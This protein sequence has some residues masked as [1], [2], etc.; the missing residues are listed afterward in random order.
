MQS[1]LNNKLYG[2]LN[3]ETARADPL[4]G[5][6]SRRRQAMTVGL[7]GFAVLV[8]ILLLAVSSSPTLHAVALGLIAPGAGFLNWSM[9]GSPL[10][11]ILAAAW[12]AAFVMALVKW[13]A[14]GNVVAPALV[15]ITSP[16]AAAS[17]G[18]LE[19]ATA[20][21][22]TLWLVPA[23]AGLLIASWLAY[24]AF[25]GL[26][27]RSRA[28]KTAA[29]CATTP[30]PDAPSASEPN[31][32]TQE[33][34][35]LMRLVL[36]RALQPVDRFEGFEWV[37]QY[38]TSAVRYQINF[39][40]YAL[41]MAQRV[42]MPAFRGYLHAAQTNLADKQQDHRV[43]RYWRSENLW[44]NLSRSPDPIPRDNIM[45]SGFVATQLALFQNAAGQ[46]PFD[47]AESLVFAHPSG[48]RFAYDLPAIIE[49][50]ARGFEQSSLGLTAC[51]PHWLY[52]LCN[53]ITAS[54]IRAASPAH[55]E[56][57]AEQL[58]E[59][60]EG[61]FTAGEGR[62]VPFRSGLTGFAPPPLGGAVM[63]AF[64]AYFLSATLPDLAWRHWLALRPSLAQDRFRCAC[65]P[66]DVG[67][68]RFTRAS[69]Y[70]GT[71][72][73]AVEFGDDAITRR[74][75]EALDAECPAILR[76]GVR[77]R[78][79]VSLWSHAVELMA[80]CGTTHSFRDLVTRSTTA[81]RTGPHLD[82][83]PYPD[84]LVAKAVRERA[85][86]RLVLYPG[87]CTGPV[88]LKLAGLPRGR[89]FFLRGISQ[90]EGRAN[91]HGNADLSLV[92]EGRTEIVVRTW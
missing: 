86:L 47:A 29:V 9:H 72:C 30:V 87:A 64:P 19:H 17:L 51:E 58:S 52:P 53:A 90:E 85:T 7:Y 66:V 50:L 44:G 27:A 69:S 11:E 32:L 25:A 10:P 22:G 68:Y 78:P 39:M 23:G 6:L 2:N 40:S 54:G 43:W 84:V 60:L 77:H 76:D 65:W 59:T 21:P 88:T 55:W 67:N 5:S 16:F 70:A 12:A 71:A 49:I 24:V 28:K 75:L 34:L 91:D 73:A 33:D 57:M 89:T 1:S 46:R 56:R 80:R 45:F 63:E 81:D 36:D 41:S 31:E 37:D 3:G 20:A 74:L 48:Q 83:A 61:E 15:W 4:F 26:L 62:F 35:Q 38:Q 82:H 13:F 42:H 79:G 92:L 18:W 8:A 14:T